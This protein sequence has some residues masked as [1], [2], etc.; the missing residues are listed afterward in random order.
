MKK[1]I[2]HT[3]LIFN[4][5]VLQVFAIVCYLPDTEGGT[6]LSDFPWDAAVHAT[7]SLWQFSQFLVLKLHVYNKIASVLLLMMLS[8]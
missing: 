1:K 6:G 5:S 7:S 2:S 4:D 3:D 8:C